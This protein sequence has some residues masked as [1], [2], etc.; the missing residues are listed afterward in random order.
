MHTHTWA[1]SSRRGRKGGK[2]E[3]RRARIYIYIYIHTHIHII[4]M[5]MHTHI[6]KWLLFAAPGACS[7][8][9]KAGRVL[10]GLTP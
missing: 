1:R 7:A 6:P 5:H 9:E 3:R 10:Y 2:S 4:Y 8:R